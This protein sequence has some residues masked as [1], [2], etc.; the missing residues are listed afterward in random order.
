MK[1][2]A[3]LVLFAASCGGSSPAETTTSPTPPT[4]PAPPPKETAFSVTVTGAG[5]PVVFVPGLGSPGSVWDATVAHLGGKVQAHVLTL[6]G[7]AGVAPIPP[8]F[9]LT[10]HEQLVDY[11]KHLDHPIVVGHSLGGVEVLWLAETNS[12]DL[13]GIVD[14]EGLPFLAGVLDPT[15]TEAKASESA[16]LIHDEMMKQSPEQFAVQTKQFLAGMITKPGDLDRIAAATAKSDQETFATAFSELMAKD[17]RADL[18][19]ITTKV[20]IIAAADQSGVPRPQLEAAWHTQ[21]DAIKG[22]SFHMVDNSKHFVMLDQ[23]DA[24]YALIDRALAGN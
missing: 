8:P 12:A 14:V 7:F 1:H 16:K 24:F 9:L 6:A 2:V 4:P 17:L 13:S 22:A 15:T 21:I 18:P 23:P 11:V 5:R 10:V 19:K 20:T 3:L